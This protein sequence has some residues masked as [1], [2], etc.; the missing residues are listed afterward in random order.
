M[1]GGVPPH[2]RCPQSCPLVTMVP[3]MTNPLNETFR[4]LIERRAATNGSDTFLMF[5]DD[6][7][8]FADLKERIDRA[9]A[10]LK[11]SGIQPGDRIGLMLPTVPDHIYLFFALAWIGAV[12]LPIS[13]HLKAMGIRTQLNSARPRMIIADAGFTE[14]SDAVAE[15]GNVEKILWRGSGHPTG[16]AR[17]VSLDKAL[18]D[19]GDI[20]EVAAGGLDRTCMISY[21]SGTTGEPKGAVLT[22]KWF[23]IGAK[24]AGL[25]AEVRP[26]DVLFLWEPFYHVA[27][28]MTVLMSLQHGVPSGMVERFSASQCWNQIRKF[29][30]TQLHYL[31]GAMNLLL[32]QPERPDDADNPV[33]IAWGAAAPTQSWQAFE[34]RFG[35]TI[36]EGYGITEAGNF[37]TLSHDGP[38]G[39]IGKAVDEFEVFI[40]G[41]DGKQLPDGEVGELVMRP[42]M[43]GITMKE[44]FGKP[45]KTAEVLRDGCVFSGDL[46]YR[47][48]SGYFY[49]SGRKKDALRRRG[50]NVSAWEVERV[51]NAHPAVEES[52]VIGVASQMGEQDIKAFIRAA[53]EQTVDPA[54]IYDWCQKH[55]A[56]YQ[57]P[58][59]IEIVEDFPR[60]PTQRIRKTELPA[61]AEAGWDAD[62]ERPK[63]KGKTRA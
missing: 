48:A 63:D 39:S 42:K 46:G 60:G 59:F 20:P 16:D 27:G 36:R 25:L 61:T 18:A 12:T 55:L 44:Y 15:D 53:P 47:D 29:G 43:P 6:V 8:T 32:K 19:G 51:I 37:T 1:H 57:L 9:A 49:F 10:G 26:G 31:G 17:F 3:T 22:E 56:Y 13:V 34:N 7:I 52:A 5:G 35:L 14:L 2:P 33:R 50:E 30:A 62:L 24:N 54:Q 38:V 4:Q 21:T 11:N 58:R 45:D 23:Q 41:E 28:W 40:A